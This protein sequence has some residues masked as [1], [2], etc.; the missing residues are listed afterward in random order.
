VDGVSDS[1]LAGTRLVPRY[2]VL[3]S[4]DHDEAEIRPRPPRGRETV[5]QEID[6]LDGLQVAH[7]QRNRSAACDEAQ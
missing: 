5:Q 4:T 1:K 2:V 6:S 3:P 7:V